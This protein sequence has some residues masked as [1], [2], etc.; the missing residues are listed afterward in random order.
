[1]AMTDTA[2]LAAKPGPWETG[3]R[4]LGLIRFSHTVFALPFALWAAVLAWT[5]P[6]AGGFPFA[7]AKVA[8]S[9][10]APPAFSWLALAG[11]LI[12]MVGARSAAMAFN[13]IVDRRIDAANPRTARRHLPSGQLSLASAALFATA[14]GGLFIAGTLLFLPN[15]LPLAASAPVLAFLFAYSYQKRFSALSHFWLGIALGLAPVAAWIAIRGETVIAYPLDLVPATMI[16]LA[17]LAWVAGF[18]II[19]AC[20]DIDFDRQAG[21][22]SVP[23]ALGLRGALRVAA[24]CHVVTIAAF[25]F[26]PLLCPDVGLGWLYAAAVLAVAALLLYEHAIVRPGDLGRANVAFFHV[27]AVISVGLCGVAIVEAFV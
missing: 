3:R 6:L 24:A 8:I 20:H 12:C 18:D 21:L 7:G 23:A 11:I 26:L 10:D 9:A 5:A 17:V 16:A 2:P 1:M 4:L 14:S 27:N 13:R 25:A 15:W 19:Y 22:H